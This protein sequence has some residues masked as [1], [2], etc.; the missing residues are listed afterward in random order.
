MNMMLGK[1]PDRL[2]SGRISK[3]E[4]R[5]RRDLAAWSAAQMMRAIV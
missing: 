4:A 3:E 5:I 1:T 2:F